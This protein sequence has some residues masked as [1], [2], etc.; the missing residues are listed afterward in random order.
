[1][2]RVKRVLER[3]GA[4]VFSDEEF[5]RVAEVLPRRIRELMKPGNGLILIWSKQAAKSIWVQRELELAIELRKHVMIQ[6]TDVTPLPEVLR[7]TVW[8]ERDDF[9]A[10]MGP[11]SQASLDLISSQLL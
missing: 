11:C 8:I 7:S 3:H 5:I 2:L 4:N 10:V 9:D 6:R 1:M